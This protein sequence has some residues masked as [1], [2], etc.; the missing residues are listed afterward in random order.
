M[1]IQGW[2][3]VATIAGGIGTLVAAVI[4]V[5]AILQARRLNMEASQ[6]YVAPFMENNKSMPQFLEVGVRNYGKTTARNVRV[7]FNEKPQVSAW[8]S[9]E[10]ITDLKFPED[11]ATLVP[12]QEWRTVWDD[13]EE[14]SKSEMRNRHTVVVSYDG[15]GKKR[16]E[17]TYVL[18]W[19]PLYA[20]TYME[21]K[22][23]HHMAKDVSN[24][25]TS[26][27][28]MV[29]VSRGLKG[30]FDVTLRPPKDRPKTAQ[31]SAPRRSRRR[32]GRSMCHRT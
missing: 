20:R 16:Q 26:L 1:G 24:I 4:A 12:G 29:T 14:R 9:V 13:G 28:R 3:N 27:G 10:E 23:I 18:D 8:G 32:R 19:E 21:E 31:R 5:I 15:L 25:K 11:L 30:T 2:A 17:E 6:P 7:V 22:T